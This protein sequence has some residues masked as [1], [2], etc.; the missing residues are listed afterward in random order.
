M[1]PEY[2][3]LV[4][5]QKSLSIPRRYSRR[6]RGHRKH[7]VED[8]D[9]AETCDVTYPKKSPKNKNHE[10]FDGEDKITKPASISV[11]PSSGS[12]R[13]VTSSLENDEAKTL[14]TCTED[15]CSSKYGKK[16]HVDRHVRAVHRKE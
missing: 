8:G 16:S 10:Q 11:K 5:N 12:K 14:D 4:K 7:N 9:Q 13:K 1:V 15:G 6:N 2:E 3:V